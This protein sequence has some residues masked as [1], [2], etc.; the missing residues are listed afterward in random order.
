MSAEVRENPLRLLCT[1]AKRGTARQWKVDD[2]LNPVLT[3][4]LL[5]GLVHLMHPHGRGDSFRTAEGHKGTVE[6][7]VKV[8]SQRGHV[9]SA[10]ALTRP[11]LAELWWAANQYRESGSRRL[12][13]ALDAE[14]GVLADDVRALLKGRPYK[15]E[16]VYRPHQPYDE[17]TWINL[18]AACRSVI[19]KSWADYRGA[20]AMAD[21][22]SDPYVHGWTVPNICWQM[23]HRAPAG[24]AEL[25]ARLNL[26]PRAA[27][28]RIGA[29]HI[30]R[31][32]C[33]ING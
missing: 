30:E 26:S 33:P 5:T 9:G 11:M 29:V 8:L 19:R 3:R 18:T 6:W 24:V 1:F 15:A 10:A 17:V 32:V 25:G 4:E 20:L 13:A 14:T 16:P 28:S 2:R 27:R 22:G 21:T 31:G 12:L 7:F 23:A